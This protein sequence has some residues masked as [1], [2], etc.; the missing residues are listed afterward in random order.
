MKKNVGM[1]DRSLRVILGVV[2]LALVYTGPARW[3]GLIGI[4]PLVTGL[5]SYCPLYAVLGI[6]RKPPAG[7]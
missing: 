7:G 1:L 6:G 5:M 2:L 3:W 4:V